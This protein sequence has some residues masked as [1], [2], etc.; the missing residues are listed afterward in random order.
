MLLVKLFKYLIIH[1]LN[2]SY[3][4][5][6]HCIQP[7]CLP[8]TT[9]HTGFKNYAVSN[10]QRNITHLVK[11]NAGPSLTPFDAINL[12]RLKISHLDRTGIPCSICRLNWLQYKFAVIRMHMTGT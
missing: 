8:L 3:F 5:T 4:P 2:A 6:V 1:F 11:R 10:A 12:N 7:F 9:L